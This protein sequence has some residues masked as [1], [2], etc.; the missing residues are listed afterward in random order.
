MADTDYQKQINEINQKL[1]LLLEYVNTERQKR[2]VLDDL[3]NDVSRVGTEI[4]KTS[5]KEL[6]ERGIEIDPEEA[7]NLIF[8]LLSNIKTFNMLL[9]TLQNV[10]DFVKDATPIAREMVID[11]TR[12]LNRLHENGV[13]DSIKTI[14][15]NLSD[16]RML[17]SLANITQVINNTHMDE[18]TDDKSL[19]KLYKELKSPEVRKGLSYT[20]RVVKA[21]TN[22][23]NKL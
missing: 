19:F 21:I 14:G 22:H 15:K 20:L 1:D 12:E 23:N 4:F 13:I 3:M 2:Q 8:T 9:S 17:Q 7:K 16:P 18:K 6:D 11:L 5:V 10:T